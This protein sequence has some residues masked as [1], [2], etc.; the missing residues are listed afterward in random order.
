M[1]YWKENG[2]RTW[3]REKQAMDCSS[4]FRVVNGSF[5]LASNGAEYIFLAV[6]VHRIYPVPRHSLD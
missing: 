2:P 4:V 5:T 1:S 6:D 3:W